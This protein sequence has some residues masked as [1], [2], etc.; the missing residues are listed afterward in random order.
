[1]MA[2]RM[3]GV[4]AGRSWV[5]QSVECLSVSSSGHDVR[6]VDQVPHGALHSA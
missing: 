3:G 1:M 6:V 2:G 5:A 4:G